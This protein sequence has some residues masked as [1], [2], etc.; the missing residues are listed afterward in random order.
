LLAEDCFTDEKIAEA[1]GVTRSTL[2]EWKKIP[3]FAG[4]V[5]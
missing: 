1:V 3:E 5:Y 4:L 2:A